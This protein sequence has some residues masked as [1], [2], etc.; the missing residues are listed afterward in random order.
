MLNSLGGGGGLSFLPFGTYKPECA[1]IVS[2]G[3]LITG[4]IEDNKQMT[5]VYKS[6]HNSGRQKFT[7]YNF[8]CFHLLCNVSDIHTLSVHSQH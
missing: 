8:H 7:C 5:P 3:L 1:L 2:M 4:G 6:Q